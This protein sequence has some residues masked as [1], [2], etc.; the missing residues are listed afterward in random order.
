MQ[1]IVLSQRPIIEKGEKM[2]QKNYQKSTNLKKIKHQIKIKTS[3]AF[4]VITCIQFGKQNNA[5][6]WE[7]NDIK[8]STKN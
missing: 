7:K 5:L 2:I 4:W 8:S 1:Q 3:I 6:N